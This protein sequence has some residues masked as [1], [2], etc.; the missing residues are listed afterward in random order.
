MKNIETLPVQ[1]DK[2]SG[3]LAGFGYRR[4][5]ETDDVYVYDVRLLDTEAHHHYEVFERKSVPKVV[6]FE[7]KEFSDTEF[8]EIYPNDEAFGVWAWNSF[9]IQAAELRVGLL[10]Q[11]IELR[12]RD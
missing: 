8:K 1:F 10:E 9:S 12:N 2:T 11:R 5:R 3:K 4:I 7:K 6:D